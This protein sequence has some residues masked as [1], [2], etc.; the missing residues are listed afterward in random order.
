MGEEAERARGRASVAINRTFDRGYH[1]MMYESSERDAAPLV[2]R[3]TL[4][5]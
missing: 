5:L 3:P 4:S 1:F 2:H